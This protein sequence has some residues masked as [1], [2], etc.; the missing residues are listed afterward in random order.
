M[1]ISHA[2]TSPPVFISSHALYTSTSSLPAL[3]YFQPLESAPDWVSHSITR[4]LS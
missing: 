3:T 4:D 2:M 1:G